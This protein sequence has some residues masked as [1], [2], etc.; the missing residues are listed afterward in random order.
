MG[1]SS[2][3]IQIDIERQRQA[4]DAR[5]SRLDRR[6]RDDIDSSKDRINERV[7]SVKEK[8]TSAGSTVGEKLSTTAGSDT[9]VAEHPLGLVGGAMA[10]GAILGVLT[11]GGDEGGR[12]QAHHNRRRFSS[13]NGAH[14]QRQESERDEGGLIGG[15]LGGLITSARGY[16]MDQASDVAQSVVDGIKSSSGSSPKRETA[17]RV[18]SGERHLPPAEDEEHPS[19]GEN[20]TRMKEMEAQTAG[21]LQYG[22]RG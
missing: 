18:Y 19:F 11:G 4:I 17:S 8:V 12:G 21:A 22:G 7:S 15:L 1:K 16:V 2:S 9:P 5:I 13:S 6:I 10:G 3:E 14:D 20:G